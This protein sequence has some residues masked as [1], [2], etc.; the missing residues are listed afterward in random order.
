M[1]Q[2]TNE[3]ESKNRC[4]K[5]QLI[6]VSYIQEGAC[7]SITDKYWK[8]WVPAQTQSFDKIKKKTQSKSSP[9]TYDE[10]DLFQD[11]PCLIC[12]TN[13]HVIILKENWD[14]WV[15]VDDA[16]V[17]KLHRLEQMEEI[18]RLKDLDASAQTEAKKVGDKDQIEM[19]DKCEGFK[20]NLFKIVTVIEIEK[21]EA[22]EVHK[23][24]DPT[25]EL[26]VL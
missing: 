25:I 15:L 13:Q 10:P 24:K 2:Q 23:G 1:I 20:S 17:L 4:R 16:H 18:Q 9:F 5:K 19:D 22:F 8:K 7:Q 26:L 11:N 12:I 3:E 14:K 6:Y 21:I